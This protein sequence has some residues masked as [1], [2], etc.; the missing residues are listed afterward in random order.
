MVDED[1]T[2]RIQNQLCVL[3]KVERKEKIFFSS[4]QH[5]IFNTFRRDKNVSR[6]KA[7][8]FLVG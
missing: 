6:F 5:S 8:L 1:G 4:P 3:D 2:L 7:I